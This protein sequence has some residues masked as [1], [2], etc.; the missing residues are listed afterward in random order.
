[1]PVLTYVNS[2]CLIGC[3]DTSR[4]NSETWRSAW[5][6]IWE[7][8]KRRI[9]TALAAC[10]L[11]VGLAVS[12]DNA[13][14]TKKLIEALQ[15]KPGSVVAEIGAGNGEL[16]VA[17]ARH[18]GP[19]GLVYT[20]ELGADR[21]RRLRE[22]VDKKA[23]TNVQIVEGHETQANLPEACC[24]AIF[25]RDV[26]HHFGDPVSMNASFFRALKPGARIAVIDF[27][28]PKEIAPPG[29]RA[30]DG[31]HG[32]TAEVTANELKAAGFEIVSSEERTKRSF[33]VVG[34]KPAS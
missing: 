15:L 34:S 19:T 11:V 3:K 22:A 24:D 13:T 4:N 32:V 2:R 7:I 28:P 18:V 14:D 17:L 25:M 23:I 29:D 8:M 30:K 20:T 21:L 16:T 27:T 1:M 31:S 6:T 33:M 26:Y 9:L 5:R 10:A 12:Q